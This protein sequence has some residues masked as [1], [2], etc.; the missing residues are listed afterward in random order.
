MDIIELVAMRKIEEAIARGEF[1]GLPQR[2][3]IDCSI[4]GEAFIIKWWREKILRDEAQ[5]REPLF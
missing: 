3:W 4:R 5:N 1:D 2:G